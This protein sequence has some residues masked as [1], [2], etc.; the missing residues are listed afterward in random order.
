[1]TLTRQHFQLVANLLRDNVKPNT[2]PLDYE[3][4]CA[5]AASKLSEYNPHFDRDRFIDACQ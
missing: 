1:M 3:Q 4:I 5:N 2:L